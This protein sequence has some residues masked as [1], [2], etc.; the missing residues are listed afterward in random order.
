MI[1]ARIMLLVGIQAVKGGNA[2]FFLNT[3]AFPILLFFGLWFLVSFKAALI[4]VA[5]WLVIFAVVL[6]IVAAQ[7]ES[8]TDVRLEPWPFRSVVNKNQIEKLAGEL[9]G[10]GFSPAGF[11]KV[12]GRDLYVEGWVRPDWKIYAMITSGDENADAYVEFSS[13][14]ADGGS[15]CVSGSKMKPVLP[16]PANMAEN[17]FPGKSVEELLGIMLRCRPDYGLLD[18]PPEKFQEA[19]ETEIQ[20][21][22]EYLFKRSR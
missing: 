5:V 20:R 21:M 15:Y 2:R 10:L 6:A 22:R 14:Y 3:F 18:T 17:N 9:A 8:L 19:V 4:V 11:F 13:A 16:R 12:A 7:V 1:N